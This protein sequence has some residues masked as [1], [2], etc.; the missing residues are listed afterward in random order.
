MRRCGHPEAPWQK[1]AAI[2]VASPAELSH[3]IEGKDPC[4][5]FFREEPDRQ[6]EFGVQE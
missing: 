1:L 6:P 3:Q 2:A 4:S 5:E